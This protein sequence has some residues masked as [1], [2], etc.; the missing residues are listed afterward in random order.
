MTGLDS[1][2]DL[3]IRLLDLDA[4][5]N[6]PDAPS[7]LRRRRKLITIAVILVGIPAVPAFLLILRSL[8]GG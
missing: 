4:A 7:W 6:L 5:A 8:F 1:L 2:L 3:F